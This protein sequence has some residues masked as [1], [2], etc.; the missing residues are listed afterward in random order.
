VDAR[1]RHIFSA[2]GDGFPA[3]IEKAAYGISVDRLEKLDHWSDGG[4]DGVSHIIESGPEYS[5]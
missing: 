3:R 4:R 2:L 1:T 5:D